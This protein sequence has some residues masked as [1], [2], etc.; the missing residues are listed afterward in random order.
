MNHTIKYWL[1]FSIGICLLLQSCNDDKSPVYEFTAAPELSPLDNSSLVLNEEAENF[2]AETF[3][4]SAGKYGFQAAPLY[5]LQIDNTESF[6]DPISLAE[7]HNLY[8]PVNVGKLNMATLILG[9]ESGIEFTYIP[10]ALEFYYQRTA[11][12]GSTQSATVVAYLWSGTYIQASVPQ[13]ISFTSPT[14]SDMQDRD[15]VILGKSLDGCQGGDI[16]QEGILVASLEHSIT[17]NTENGN[18]DYACIPFTYSSTT[19]KP[20]KLNIIFAANDYFAARSANVSGDQLVID[21]V[22]LIYYHTLK[23]LAYEG[24]S[25]TFDEET[26]T[27]DLSNVEYEAGKLSFEKKAAGGTAVA[28][29]DETTAKV[30]IVVTSDDKLNST[31][32]ELQFKMPVSYT[33][34]LSSI[35]YN[36]TPLEGFTENTHYYS[37]TADY[38]AD[39]LTATASDE[40]LTPTISY[41]AESRIATISVPESGQ[42]INYYVK[43]A[44]K[45]TPY[46]S[47]LLITMV[48]MY[49]SAP[50]QE[51]GIT[52]NEDGTIGFQ[53]IGFEFSGVNMG[54]IYVDD[55]AMDG[56]GNIYKEDV[57]Q[58]FGDFGVDLGDL[59][60][61]LK[62]QLKDGELE[63]NLD[64]TWVNGG[65]LPIKVTVYPPTTP[66]ID[67][68]GISSLNVA[69]VQEGLTN[70]NCI[71]YTDEG[72]TVSE[73]SEN[74][75]V[76]TSCTK[77]NL[78]KSNDISNGTLSQ[79]PNWDDGLDF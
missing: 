20:A 68:Q 53:L 75:V 21:D 12:S 58:I 11:A 66:Y 3:S 13:S 25:L 69:A 38:T 39:C 44:K 47:K 45:A 50:T 60:I 52:E 28:T 73:G 61:T 27:Y 32:Y 1:F 14:Q 40:G 70:P 30:S 55:I 24:E 26:L 23:S 31:T 65:N 67:A 42:N 17:A 2:I 4:W 36:G 51:V 10:D 78:N 15:R 63:C 22:K 19:T 37:L 62:G 41:D 9:G 56:D 79:N 33:G 64:I 76:G 35:S 43:F 34:K 5:T 8:L 77:L 6:S 57:I 18:W 16:T 48:G 71:I 46:P 72:T 74:V 59:P 54:D 49:L 7:T 29:Y